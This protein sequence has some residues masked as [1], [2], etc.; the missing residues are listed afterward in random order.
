MS[1]HV[2]ETGCHRLA[3]RIDLDPADPFEEGLAEQRD[4][5]V[6]PNRALDI[7]RFEWAQ[8]VAFDGPALKPFSK[9]TLAQANAETLRVRLQPYLTL[10]RQIH[11]SQFET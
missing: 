5:Q 7:A 4:G 11:S 10:L 3:V 6:A 2:D 8:V 9:K 1:E